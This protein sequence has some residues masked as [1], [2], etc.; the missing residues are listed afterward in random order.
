ML[1]RRRCGCSS[2]RRLDPVPL[3]LL[4][5]YQSTAAPSSKRYGKRYE[6][7]GRTNFLEPRTGEVLRTPLPRTPLNKRRWTSERGF[8]IRV[9]ILLGRRNKAVLARCGG[10][11]EAHDRG[12]HTYLRPR[13]SPR[14]AQRVGVD[15]QT[16]VW[17]SGTRHLQDHG[18]GPQRRLPFYLDLQSLAHAQG[19]APEP[20]AT[21]NARHG[22]QR[23]YRRRPMTGPSHGGRPSPDQ[24]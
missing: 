23:S 15:G 8:V 7:E 1:A 24:R 21:R 13:A 3:F 2:H 6:V 16:S 19:L 4:S 17:R 22:G 12:P 11:K 5:Q 14:A 9:T 10:R 20:P 18:A